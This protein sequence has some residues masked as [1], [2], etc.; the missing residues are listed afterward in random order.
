M[1]SSSLPFDRATSWLGATISFFPALNWSP[2]LNAEAA[3]TITSYRVVPSEAAKHS[4]N[5]LIKATQCWTA[6]GGGGPHLPTALSPQVQMKSAL[7]NP[8]VSSWLSSRGDSASLLQVQKQQQ[9]RPA[10]WRSL[11]PLNDRQRSCQIDSLGRVELI[12]HFRWGKYLHRSAAYSAVLILHNFVLLP[13]V[14]L[15]SFT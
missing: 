8:F 7:N 14:T 12:S 9:S 10:A 13:P 4:V 15:R 11:P 3:A 5:W 2:V 1:I 6:G